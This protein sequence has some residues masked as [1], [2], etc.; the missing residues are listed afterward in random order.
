[1]GKCFLRKTEVTLADG[2]TYTF[3]ALPFNKR[4][5]QMIKILLDEN[6]DDIAVLEALLEAVEISL[7]YDQNEEEIRYIMDNGLIPMGKSDDNVKDRIIKAL[8][9][10]L[11]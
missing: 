5:V 7:S 10:G 6:T 4:S 2:K 9:D 3:R 8:V 11:G 1:M